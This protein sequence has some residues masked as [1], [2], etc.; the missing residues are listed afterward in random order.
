MNAFWQAVGFLS[1]FP[2]PSKAQ[3]LKGWDHS[4]R[5]YPLVGLLIG[6]SLWVVGWLAELGFG[7]SA[8]AVS[9]AI[10]VAFWIYITGALH[11]DGLMDLADGL[12]SYRSRERML[13]IM[14]DSRVGAMGVV[15]AVI[16]IVIKIVA[17]QQLFVRDEL[18]MIVII[19]A[20][21]R[22]T[23]LLAI[24]YFPYIQEKGLG[25][26][27]RQGV[28]KF[29]LFLN[30]ILILAVLYFTIGLH[31]WIVFGV[32]LLVGWLFSRSIVR[33]LGGFTG[34]VYGALIETMETLVLLLYLILLNNPI[35]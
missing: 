3:T 7:T 6:C 33:K 19:P 34:D 1:R 15:V 18:I 2:V 16:L 24:Y 31:G 29:S 11:L 8:I 4:P 20:M 12:G 23:L 22:F 32:M 9:A 27:L 25:S 30:M 21:A 28:N 14:K 5:Y 26:G 17:V 13:E 10:S 35:L